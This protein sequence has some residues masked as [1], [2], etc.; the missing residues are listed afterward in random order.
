MALAAGL[1][2]L[3]N[4][5]G[6]VIRPGFSVLD[7]WLSVGHL[8]AAGVLFSVLLGSVLAWHGL[9]RSFQRA[10][11]LAAAIAAAAALAALLDTAA[12]Y[13]AL[14]RGSVRT[15]VFVPASLPLAV[16]LFALARSVLRSRP[17]TPEGPR[18]LVLVTVA[19]VL[20][21]L[22]LIR[23]FS[24]GLSRYERP[25]DVAVVFGAR[26][27]ADGAPSLALADRVDEAVRAYH[28]GLVR[29]LLMSG[30][31]DPHAQV[32]EARVMRDRA[33]RAGVPPAAIELDES[34]ASTTLT[35]SNAARLLPS[36]ARVLL[37]SHYFHLPRSA[38]LFRRHGFC[39]SRSRRP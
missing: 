2:V 34:G 38:L 12:F 4:A 35:A 18:W 27:Y 23:I 28:G 25:C 39:R 20:G 9:C 22:P 19:A 16:G 8:G 13:E 3:A 1:F 33:V 5:V 21:A 10:R 30:G 36:G 6:E 26:A 15:P 29:R 24:F 17:L 32:S 7:E 11:V 31:V 37:V 14:L